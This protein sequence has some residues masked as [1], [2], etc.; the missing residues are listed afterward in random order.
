MLNPTPSDRACL[1]FALHVRLGYGPENDIYVLRDC[2]RVLVSGQIENVDPSVSPMDALT[3]AL[4]QAMKLHLTGI[5]F[6]KLHRDLIAAGMGIEAANRVHDHLVDVSVE[7]WDRL[8]ERINWY[9]DDNGDPI[10][11]STKASGGT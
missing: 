9:G 3:V 2:R 6:G 7:E 11:A 8:R 5:N 10:T 1:Q 4:A